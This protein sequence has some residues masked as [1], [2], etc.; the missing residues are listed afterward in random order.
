MIKIGNVFLIN[1]L[2]TLITSCKY[3]RVYI[4]FFT[5]RFF[6]EF[7]MG[8]WKYIILLFSFPD[9]VIWSIYL[10][11]VY[12]FEE[13]HLHVKCCSDYW[14][15]SFCIFDVVSILAHLFFSS[16]QVYNLE[17]RSVNLY[18]I[19]WWPKTNRHCSSAERQLK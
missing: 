2:S 13:S 15:S 7:F 19:Y 8:F 10:T 4:I 12:C 14:A 9:A 1:S 3:V 5:L 18:L 6:A 16:C 17:K 11:F